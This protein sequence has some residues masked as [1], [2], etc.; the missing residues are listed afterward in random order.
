MNSFLFRKF[1]KDWENVSDPKVRD[2]YGKLA[3]II[4]IISNTLLC[5]MKMI[6]G[7]ISGSI[8]IVADAVNNLADASS[9][10]I[11]LI[12][13]KLASLPEDKEHPYGHARIE[14][15]AGMVVSMIIIIIGF[16][17]GKSSIGKILHPQPLE[18]S[19]SVVAVLLLAIVIKI[20][21]AVFNIAAGRKINSITLIATGT[22]SRNDVISTSAVLISVI[23]GHLANVQIDGYIGV[24]VALFIIWS[25]I[26][27][28]KETI[29]P[30]LGE[31]PDTELV[32]NI[33]RIASDYD[34]VIGI[35]D[36][37]VHNYG[38]GK[39]FASLHIEVDGDMDIMISHDIVDNI[40]RRLQNELNIFVT[41]HLDPVNL[42]DENREP[43]SALITE[44]LKHIDGFINFHDL[45]IVP[46]NTH[47]NV[48]FDV[49]I[50]PDCKTPR[51]EIERIMS[52]KI[53][54]YNNT[55]FCVINFDI[56]YIKTEEKN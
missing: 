21:Q 27:L 45:R 1:I 33:E 12:G 48:I 18:F 24:L 16:E 29:S 5:I 31:A 19:I 13:F 46:G 34:E 41:A 44:T 14:Y 55:F 35:H 23:I 3:G 39:V 49:V 20:W 56:S 25:G 40:E 2:R 15:I 17:L 9:S 43:I 28:V 53:K 26:S 52:E 8:A 10:V 51:E 36:L 38:P 37:V 22:D 32:Q 7:V 50:S 47:T 11:T 42:K 30:L 54:E 4:G 6:V